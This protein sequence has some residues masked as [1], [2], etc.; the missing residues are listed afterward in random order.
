MSIVKHA[1]P[2]IFIALGLLCLVIGAVFF[3]LWTPW[4]LARIVILAAGVVS[5]GLLARA[6]AQL[7]KQKR[8]S[9][10]QRI[11][12]LVVFIV[13]WGALSA[14]LFGYLTVVNG[15]LDTSEARVVSL[16][17][18]D[19]SSRAVWFSPALRAGS[20]GRPYGG[21]QPTIGYCA[22]VDDIFDDGK[23]RA[24][25]IDREVFERIRGGNG[26]LTVEYKSGLF[27]FAWIKR[28][29]GPDNN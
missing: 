19:A 15:V 17:V 5:I 12:G 13:I 20:I 3:P 16:R 1:R 8:S 25:R 28:V 18:R 14:A 21:N 7:I 23:T 11:A 27:G 24:L 26:T 9:S 10:R 29:G 4:R 22:E 6:R 2:F